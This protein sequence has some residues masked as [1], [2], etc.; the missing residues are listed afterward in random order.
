MLTYKQWHDQHKD[1]LVDAWFDGSHGADEC[2]TLSDF[3]HAKW[4]EFD[5]WQADRVVDSWRG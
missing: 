2:D 1:Q 3:V 4:D 5:E